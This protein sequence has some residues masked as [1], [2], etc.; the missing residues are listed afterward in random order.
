M[1]CVIS[2]TSRPRAATSVA[3]SVETRPDSN[4]DSERSRAFWDMFPC[5][6]RGAHVV[7]AHELAGELVGAVLGADEDER[8]PA[9]APELLDQPVELVVGGHGNELVPDVAARQSR[10]ARPVLNREALTV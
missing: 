3:I 7:V 8:E 6:H 4:C 2:S 5:M 1:T 10:S 9:L